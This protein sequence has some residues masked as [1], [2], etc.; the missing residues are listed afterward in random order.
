MDRGAW[1]ATVHEVTQSQTR[2]KRLSTKYRS[3][4][5]LVNMLLVC[6]KQPPTQGSL[7]DGH[8]GSG[9]IKGIQGYFMEL[10]NKDSG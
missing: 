5:C 8:R 3:L 4:W 9:F 2:L 7:R 1:G 6:N 10:K